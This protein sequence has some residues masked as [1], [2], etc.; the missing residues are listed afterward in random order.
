MLRRYVHGAGIDDPV[1]LYEGSVV[2]A[3]ALRRLRSNHQGSVVAVTGDAGNM[4]AINSYDEWGI[5]GA[6]NATIATGGRFQYTGQA[7][8][9]E[10][11][12]YYYKARIYSAT[13]GRF[14]QTDPIGYEDQVNL[15]AYVGND[16]LNRSDPT[17]L[18]DI[19]IGGG[20]DTVSEIVKSYATQQMKLYP[21]RD[22]QYYIWDNVEAISTAVLTTPNG[23][24]LNV[25]G[26]SLGGAEAMRQN[27]LNYKSIDTLV[28]IDPVDFPGDS[29]DAPSANNI[30]A[31][32]WINV[33]ANPS[34]WNRSDYVAALGGKVS[35]E[36]TAGADIQ[37]NSSAN[38]G[39]FGTM[40]RESGAQSA[41]NQTYCQSSPEHPC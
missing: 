29:I 20:A 39:A 9:P 24:P 36:R 3:A 33:T 40:M 32:N 13:L 6:S 18:R 38:H 2:T 25:I 19:Y 34:S 41:V 12:M 16:P 26:H 5:P 27:G 28:T 11:G 30:D 31:K 7:W 22:I 35:S 4:I 21:E 10:L 23:E 8:I 37:V 1:I 15:Y 17:G 14:M